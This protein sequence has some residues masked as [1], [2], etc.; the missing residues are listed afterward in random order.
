VLPRTRLVAREGA[1]VLSLPS[2]LAA[3]AS[4][5]LDNRLR[6]LSRVVG[7]EPRIDAAA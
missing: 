7:L 3:L 1:A 2:D 4:E 5:Q 6:Q